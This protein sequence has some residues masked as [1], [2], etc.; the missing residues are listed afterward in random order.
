MIFNLLRIITKINPAFGQDNSDEVANP[1]LDNPNLF[2]LKD[3]RSCF[4]SKA[5]TS[6]DEAMILEYVAPDQLNFD[7]IAVGEIVHNEDVAVLENTDYP[8]GNPG[9]LTWNVDHTSD[10]PSG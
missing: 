7:G 5:Q 8:V 3:S 2:P 6:I 10:I 9:E 1:L 4:E